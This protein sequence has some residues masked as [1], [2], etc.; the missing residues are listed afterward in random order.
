MRFMTT[1]SGIACGDVHYEADEA[2]VMDIADG[3][4]ALFAH[5]IAAGVLTLSQ[6]A[7]AAVPEPLTDAP[8]VP[9]AEAVGDLPAAE[10]SAE[11]KPADSDQLV[12]PEKP[13][14]KKAKNG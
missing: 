11:D 14:R 4:V 13:A 6:E 5:Q 12:A 8:D 3:H 2:G 10:A 9:V 7:P 1:A